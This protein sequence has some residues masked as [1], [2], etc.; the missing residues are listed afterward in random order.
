MKY[1]IE[2]CD[3]VFLE[4]FMLLSIIHGLYT[5]R[6]NLHLYYCPYL[7]CFVSTFKNIPWIRIMR[8]RCPWTRDLICFYLKYSSAEIEYWPP[9][10]KNIFYETF[11]LI[12]KSDIFPLYL[13]MSQ[14]Y[15]VFS[16]YLFV[17]LIALLYWHI[18]WI[19]YVGLCLLG[20]LQ[21]YGYIPSKIN[22]SKYFN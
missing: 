16:F 13:C 7:K 18:L 19:L 12:I 9:P 1:F 2:H 3:Y 5:G 15:I 14:I 8:I 6:T 4:E 17:E 10:M 11:D 21:L 22:L 20:E